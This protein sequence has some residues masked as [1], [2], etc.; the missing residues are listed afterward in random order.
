MK[1]SLC[2]FTIL[3]VILF[4]STVF[5]QEKSQPINIG[6]YGGIG[7]NMHNPDFS[8]TIN[9]SNPVNFNQGQSGISPF[10]G[11]IG[12]FPINSNFSI[13][14]RIGYFN[15]NGLI[16]GEDLLLNS[17]EMD[18]YLHYLE[19]S[20]VLQIHN[21]T[22]I[23]PLYFLAG[24]E[25]GL[26]LGS[27]YDYKVNTTEI[28]EP[29]EL[30]DPALRFALAIGAGYTFDISKNIYLTPEVSYRFPFTQVSSNENYD[31]WN[32]PQLRF[33]VNLTFGF[34]DD[35]T[36]KTDPSS[37]YFDLSEPKFTY[38]DDKMN[39]QPLDKIK[40]EEVQY[41]E[42]YPFIPYVFFPENKSIPETTT[43]TL[44]AQNEAGEFALT[45]LPQDAFKINSYTLDIIGK[46]LKDARSQDLT[47]TGTTDSKEARINKNLAKERAD[48]AKNYLV[49]N[50]AADPNKITIIAGGLPS[51]PSAKS[52]PEGEA[53]NRRVEFTG[54][55]DILKPIVI[56]GDKDRV[57]SPQIVD[58][59]VK[60]TTD[61]EVSNYTLKY[62]QAGTLIH[63]I[64]GSGMPN[65]ISWQISPNQLL[66]KQVPVDW[67]FT[68][69]SASNI[70]RTLN[71]SIPV[72]Y[73]SFSRKKSEN[74]PDKVVSKF[75][76][77]LFDFDSPNISDLDKQIL[78]KN[79]IPAI[80]ANSTIQIYGYTDRIGD[81]DYNKKLAQQRAD[82]VRE[83]LAGKVKNVKFETFGI[84]ESVQIYNNNYTTG[85]QLS[86]T[87]QIYV[88]TPKK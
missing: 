68:S 11:L 73:F 38:Y 59:Q 10:I 21:L 75:S 44:S 61:D 9:S 16:E 78:E 74:L 62:F 50:Y 63:Q 84:G 2:L 86:R 66:A 72:D 17:Y 19:I 60:Y 31:S 70:T 32:I 45:N 22:P 24:L 64:E 1:K 77:V 48:F 52:D 87:V 13:S 58:F 76:L 41:T 35:Q 26:P 42:L 8:E 18:T 65:N 5:S 29:F 14:G 12:N 69:T 82:N 23:K 34:E 3:F 49:A 39:A 33:G 57:T 54:N 85:R 27:T 55:S 20:P 6:L 67:E 83:Y 15:L 30:T 7:I 80:S 88:I 56:S 43:A 47:I 51:K 81:A 79:V 37:K 71:G 28:A 53:E 40:V 25:L 36:I 46:R 4:N